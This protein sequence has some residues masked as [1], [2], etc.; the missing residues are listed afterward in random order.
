MKSKNLADKY[1][2]QKDFSVLDI[3]LLILAL[4]SVIVAI[5]IPGGMPI[6]LPVLFIC[7]F[8]FCVVRSQI[9][10][11][12][13]IDQILENII[14]NNQI[15]LSDSTIVGFDLKSTV[16]KKRKDGKLVSPYYYITNVLEFSSTGFVLN[17]YVVDIINSSVKMFTQTIN[18]T[19]KSTLIEETI[20]T[21][22]GDAK[23]S[24]LKVND[25]CIIPV[26]INDFKTSQVVDMICNRNEKN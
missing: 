21:N 7:V 13:E 18:D 14:Q 5:F 12:S 24:Y 10:K 17:I 2:H 9:I 1:F 25:N 4:V 16:V 3:F 11:D 20:K 26:T 6:G 23:I 19:E 15:P 8:A 22:A